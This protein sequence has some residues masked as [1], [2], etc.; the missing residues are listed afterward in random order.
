MTAATL[1]IVALACLIVSI[2]Q[3]EDDPRMGG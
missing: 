2:F 3:D 1:F